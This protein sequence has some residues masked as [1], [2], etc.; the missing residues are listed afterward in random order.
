[1]IKKRTTT[2]FER[3]EADFVNRHIIYRT[4]LILEFMKACNISILELCTYISIGKDSAYRY[5]YYERQLPL[6]VFIK[7]CFFFKNHMKENNIPYTNR[8]L[9][10]IS[11]T[12][13]FN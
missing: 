7:C 2:V 11:L 5:L 1:M 9:E 8:I 13:L 6:G 3:E 4:Q 12:S 10:L